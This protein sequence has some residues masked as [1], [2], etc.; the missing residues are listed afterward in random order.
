MMSS[1]KRSEGFREQKIFPLYHRCLILIM[2]FVA[3]IRMQNA[4]SVGIDFNDTRIVITGPSGTEPFS[5]DYREIQSITL[6]DNYNSGTKVS[7]VQNRRLYYGTFHND[8][9]GTYAL[10][11]V[12]SIHLQS[13][14]GLKM[15]L[16]FLTTN[17]KK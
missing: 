9:Y 1:H 11:A 17:R 3:A 16:S 13:R 10:C 2:V 8:V 6:I 14:S 15:V 5:I 4:A 12:P 7:G